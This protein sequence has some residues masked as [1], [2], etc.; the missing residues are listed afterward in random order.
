MTKPTG[1]VISAGENGSLEL[2]DGISRLWKAVPHLD[3]REQSHKRTMGK[4]MG[5]NG[6]T[7]KTDSISEDG[8]LD[9][10]QD[11]TGLSESLSPGVPTH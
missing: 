2:A 5:L 7:C 1:T 9:P 8:R 11:D 6:S 3:F 10:S 4:R